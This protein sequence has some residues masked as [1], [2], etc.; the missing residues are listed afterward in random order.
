MSAFWDDLA[1][2]MENEEF[3]TAFIA[4]V[5]RLA[6]PEIGAVACPEWHWWFEREDGSTVWIGPCHVCGADV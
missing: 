1:S 6:H 4:E 3:A 5:E 2:D